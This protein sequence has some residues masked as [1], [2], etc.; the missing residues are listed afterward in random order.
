MVRRT[1]VLVG[2]S[3][4]LLELLLLTEDGGGRGGGR[5]GLGL[6]RGGRAVLFEGL[7]RA[8]PLSGR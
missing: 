5:G 2:S 4:G 1:R 7:G 8:L 3:Q 6:G